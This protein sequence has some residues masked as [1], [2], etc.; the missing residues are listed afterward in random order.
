MLKIDWAQPTI[1]SE[2][3]IPHDLSWRQRF[4]AAFD[5]Y[6]QLSPDECEA[7]YVVREGSPAARMVES[8]EETTTQTRIALVGARGSGKSTEL[9]QVMH[10]LSL[11]GGALV[12]I[13]VDIGEGLPDDATT[14]AW[15][16]V[17]AAAVRAAREDWAG[18]TPPND[19]L[20]KALGA[21]G[22]SADL[23]NRLLTAVRVV[24][25]W[26][27]PTGLVAAGAAQA[28][29]PASEALGSA[30]R[31]ALAA[32]YDRSDLDS[33]I[34]ALRDELNSLRAAAGRGAV[35][36]LDGLDK[37]PTADAVFDAL[38]EADLLLGLPAALVL[39]GPIQLQL[40]GRCEAFLTPGRFQPQTV[41]NIPVVDREGASKDSGTDLLF[42]LYR[43]RW[44]DTGLDEEL[45]G[46]P[47][48]REAARW[49][50]GIVREFLT[51]V[52]DTGKAAL[53]ERR[54]RAIDADLTLAL[55][56]RRHVMEI[57]LDAERWEVLGKVLEDR[58]RPT[59]RFDELLLQNAII[60]YQN[61]S[62][63]FRPNELLVP[64]LKRRRARDD[65]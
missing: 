40:D 35:L 25:P 22:I 9:R 8:L 46:E 39:S 53:R 27:G 65:G 45:V 20:P 13:L 57:T 52:R 50:S 10:A 15:L 30:S 12:P 19:P 58:E 14:V 49:S 17:L 43:R 28:V 38:S 4:V 64:Y 11:D 59:N 1:C 5:P 3:L 32:K 51:L 60:C 41:H 54:T 44:K 26:F 24:G 34:N 33:L 36:L 62:I 2:V 31:A 42:E 47:L 21:I 18:K 37:R 23:L 7:L 29:E 61:D 16:P 6:R 56:E 48:V 63:W 55:R